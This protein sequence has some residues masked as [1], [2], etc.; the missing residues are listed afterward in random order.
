M[1][2]R[3]IKVKDTAAVRDNRSSAILF[4]NKDLYEKARKRKRLLDLQD[5]QEL[6]INTLKNINNNLQ[7]RLDRLE[8]LIK[9]K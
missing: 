3:F 7:A 2:Q 6:E 4:N 5:R 8:K 1:T 9:E